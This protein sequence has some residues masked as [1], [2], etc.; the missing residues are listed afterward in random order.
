MAPTPHTPF[1]AGKQQPRYGP[2]S[3]PYESRAALPVATVQSAGD[4]ATYSTTSEQRRRHQG[5]AQQP[6]LHFGGAQQLRVSHGS[7]QQQTYYSSAQQGF[8]VA[9]STQRVPAVEPMQPGQHSSTAHQLSVT[10]PSTAATQNRRHTVAELQEGDHNQGSTLAD[11]SRAGVL[12]P[13]INRA[14][15]TYHRSAHKFGRYKWSRAWAL[16]R[17]A[18]GLA[19][20]RHRTTRT[21]SRL[22][23]AAQRR[24]LHGSAAGSVLH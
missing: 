12:L 11:R 19:P 18:A 21:V 7:V 14:R 20:R 6:N 1:E 2:V 23:S 16:Q 13:R 4:R 10:H 5:S 9:A 8:A 22:R 17:S 24:F 3:V 15:L